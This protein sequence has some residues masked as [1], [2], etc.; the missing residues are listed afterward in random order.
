VPAL[1][2]VLAYNRPS[3]EVKGINNLQAEYEKQYG[4]GNYVPFVVMTYWS[5]RAMVGAGLLMVLLALYALYLVLSGRSAP[6]WYLR[7]LPLAIV[8]PYLANTA[9]WILTEMGRQP[10]IVFGLL[11]TEQAVSPGVAGGMVL[12]SLLL[13]TIVYGV[14]MAADV[15]LLAKYAKADPSQVAADAVPTWV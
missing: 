5:F 7:W 15:Y 13:F 6:K 11:K 2:S 10:W 14:L 3:G 1:L 4:P 8:L 12:V 9:G